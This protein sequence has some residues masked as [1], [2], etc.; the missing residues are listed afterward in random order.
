M[1]SRNFDEIRALPEA[2][3]LEV[4]LSASEA[5][6]LTDVAFLAEIREAI[7][8]R[9]QDPRCFALFW[10]NRQGLT[11]HAALGTRYSS[12]DPDRLVKHNEDSSLLFH[13]VSSVLP[14]LCA[15]RDPDDDEGGGPDDE[16]VVDP[17]PGSPDMAQS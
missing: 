13:C 9:G 8:R 4:G 6:T 11:T 3:L 14:L 16:P 2:E 7:Q 15:H 10:I 5:E 12:E 1:F 17:D